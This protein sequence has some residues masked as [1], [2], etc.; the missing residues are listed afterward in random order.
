MPQYLIVIFVVVLVA[1]FMMILRRILGIPD[2]CDQTF[3]ENFLNV[4]YM[5]SGAALYWALSPFL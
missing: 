2:A 1:L 5:T 4:A 3:K